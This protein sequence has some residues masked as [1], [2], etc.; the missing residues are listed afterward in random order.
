MLTKTRVRVLVSHTDFKFHTVLELSRPKPLKYHNKH[1]NMSSDMEKRYLEALATISNQKKPNLRALARKFDLNYSTLWGRFHGRKPRTST[2]PIN[3]ALNKVQEAALVRYIKQLDDL[4]APCTLQEIERCANSILARSGQGPVSK[5]WASRFVR[6][7]PEGFFWIKQKPIDKKRLESEDIA[8]ITTWFEHVSRWIKDISPKNIYNFDETGF[9][10]GQG[11]AQ[12]VITQYQYSSEKTGAK[13]RG[14][15][16]TSIECIAADGWVMVP[17]II[18]KGQTHMEDW[19]RDNPSLHE[20]YNIQ[21][22]P[23]G[24]SSDLIALEWIHLFHENT[25]DRVGTNGKRV[26]FFDGHG[27]HLTFEFLDFYEEHLIIPISFLPHTS[28]FAQPLDQKPFL[29]LKQHFRKENTLTS[30]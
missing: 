10:L 18:F 13:D 8:H 4:W 29:S 23:N 17:Y 30:A 24:W 14:Q 7:L 27:S 6:R 28:H 15:I 19:F 16:V 22:S 5:M 20:E 11:R 1:L 12:K 2:I 25:K 9:Q 3:K 26:L 21:V